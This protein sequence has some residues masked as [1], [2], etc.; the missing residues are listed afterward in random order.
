MKQLDFAAASHVYKS[1]DA[2]KILLVENSY[3]CYKAYLSQKIYSKNEAKR[4]FYENS[5][6]FFL[7][8]LKSRSIV[9]PKKA[10]VIVLT[11][12]TNQTI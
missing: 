2:Q 4:L 9:T 3:L 12:Q 5:E 7:D 6:S 1:D 10:Q 11:N 8:C